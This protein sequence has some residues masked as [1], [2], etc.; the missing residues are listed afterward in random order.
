MR[1]HLLLV[2][3]SIASLTGFV[4][5]AEETPQ[6]KLAVGNQFYEK[7]DWEQA[8]QSYLAVTSQGFEGSALDYNIGNVYYRKGERGKA[9]LW[10][11]RALRLS[12]RDNDIEFNLTLA[13]SH[14]KD[15]GENWAHRLVFFF[16]EKELGW[17]LTVLGWIFFFLVAGRILGWL[18]SDAAP[19]GI[20]VSGLLLSVSVAWFGTRVVL[21]KRPVAV[22][23]S[24]PGEVRN[25]PGA[26][27]AVG[28]TIPEGSSVIVLDRRPEWSQVGVPQQGLKGWMPSRE[29]EAIAPNSIS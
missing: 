11:E 22:L 8:L 12:P 15:E 9:V 27:Y 20:W 21:A 28:F 6:Q 23:I 16:S 5:A 19:A 25:G 26:D 13:R 4:W 29:I 3:I 1:K 24:P 14:I 7:G 18:S 2:F 17:S 10:Y